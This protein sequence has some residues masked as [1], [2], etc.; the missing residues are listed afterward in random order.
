M[1]LHRAF[2][3]DE[4]GYRF[5]KFMYMMVHISSFGFDVI[6]NFVQNLANEI[7]N[8]MIGI[9]KGKLEKAFGWHSMLM[10]MFLFKGAIYF[11]G[12]M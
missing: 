7:H 10:H 3:E 11:K 2:G 12:E 6:F 9:S 4:P 5:I 1:A 8:V